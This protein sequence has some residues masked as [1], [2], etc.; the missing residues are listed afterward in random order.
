MY[1]FFHEQDLENISIIW[2]IDESLPFRCNESA[3][4]AAMQYSLGADNRTYL[5]MSI[6]QY[7]A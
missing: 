5:Q 6:H 2:V 3:A 1:I 4:F 7:Q